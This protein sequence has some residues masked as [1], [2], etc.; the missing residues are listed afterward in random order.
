MYRIRLPSGE[1]AVFRTVDE[2]TLAVRSGVLS[3]RSEV[4]HKAADRWLPIEL[5][6]DYRAAVT[7]KRPVVRVETTRTASDLPLPSQAA[8]TGSSPSQPAA[9][10]GMAPSAEAW[11]ALAVLGAPPLVPPR[12]PA[13]RK[14]LVRRLAGFAAV[15]GVGTI[16]IGLSVLAR[17]RLAGWVEAAQAPFRERAEGMGPSDSVGDSGGVINPWREP[18]PTIYPAPSDPLPLADRSE[19]ESV[20]TR[21]SRLT[22]GRNPTPTYVE[23]YAEARAEMDEALDYIRFHRVFDQ[24]RFSSI[25]SLRAASRMLAAATNI[26]AAYRGQEVKLEQTYRPADPGG[27]GSFRESFETAEAAR[28]MLVDVDSLFGL[29]VAQAGHFSYAG[30]SL[31]FSEPSTARQYTELR[32][33]IVGRL[34]AWRS[35]QDLNRGTTIPRL[36]L[37]L[38][39]AP[40]PPVR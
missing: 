25:D 6:P 32:N 33:R 39:A 21:I 40:P 4:F 13:R 26:L 19:L 22:A 14:R 7:G 9:K 17:P 29:L 18:V 15:L 3:P 16:G 30:G 27:S 34:A 20:P 11:E 24:V 23:A 12:K 36:L 31:S 37:A 1:E 35:P 5:H 2:L 38:G 28:A 10:A 8:T